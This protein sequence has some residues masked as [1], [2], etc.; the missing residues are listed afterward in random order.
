[1]RRRDTNA[2]NAPAPA[3]VTGCTRM[4]WK[5]EN[6]AVAI[7]RR[8]MSSDRQSRLR[9][10]GIPSDTSPSRILRLN[11]VTI[12]TGIGMSLVCMT[13]ASAELAAALGAPTS[14]S[15]AD[16]GGYTLF[17]PTPNT[18]LRTFSPDRPTKSNGPITV[19]AGRFQYETDLVSY[20][21]SNV[22]G[23]TTRTFVAL[24][25]TL[26][27]GLTRRVDLELQFNGYTSTR[28]SDPDAGFT[29]SRAN[30]AG[31]L[32]V[33]TK[34]NLFGNEGGAVALAL[35]PYVK[36][37][38][39]ARNLG[40]NQVEGGMIVPLSMTLPAGFSLTLMPEIDVLEN[41][42]NHGKHVNFTGVVNLG[43]SINKQWTVFA[44]LYSAVGTDAHTPPVYTAD[45]ALAFLLTETV[46]LDVGVN[47]GLNRNAPNL[48]LYTGISQRF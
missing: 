7:E 23:V 11:H 18:A 33:R 34:F 39:A 13:S 5:V 35:L 47:V 26:K 37:P 4:L 44:E 2:L 16:K 19:D 10:M 22:G 9:S 28:V 25:P 1:M 8:P 6:E 31:D 32:V 15:A 20:L 36:V 43:Y 24:D 3:D 40:N 48:Q 38:T 41:N 30:G 45:S 42:N 12:L 46:Q 21:H 29:L 17:D 27:I 14:P